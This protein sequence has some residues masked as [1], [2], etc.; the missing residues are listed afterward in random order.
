MD[1]LIYGVWKGRPYD[2]RRRLDGEQP[3]DLP[4][5]EFLSFNPGNPVTGFVGPQGFLIFDNRVTLAETLYRYYASVKQHSCGRCTPCRMG[6]R[7]IVEALEL[8][9][10]GR[11]SEV[12][13]DEIGR[14]ALQMKETSLCGIGETTPEAVLGAIEYFPELLRN[15]PATPPGSRSDHYSIATAPCIEACPANVNIPRYIDYV[16]DG[17][18]DLATGVLLEHY[19]LVGSCGRVCVR[20]CERACVRNKVDKAVAIKD[21]KR[22]ASD[23]AGAPIEELFCSENAPKQ[24]PVSKRVAVVGAGPAGITCAYHLLKLGHFV[25]IYE[26]ESAAGGMARLG[27]PAYRLPNRLLETE[28]EVISRM[29][30]KYLFNQALGRDFNIDDLFKKGYKAVFLGIGCALGQTLGLPGDDAGID[31]Y[32]KGLDFLLDV[33]R[34]EADRP[35]LDGDVVVVGCGNVAMD[36]CRTAR[37]LNTSGKVTVS[38][39]RTQQ[40]APADP[41]EIIAAKA[42][43]I[44]FEFLTAPKRIIVEDGRV[45]GIELVRMMETEPDASGRRGVKPIEGSE[46]IIPCRYVVAAIGQKMDSSIFSESDGI[47]LTRRGTIA[48][49]E[50]LS[51]SREGVF[52]G[53]DA[54]AGPTS[55]IAGMADGQTAAKSI[56]EYLMVEDTGFIPRRRLG[57]MIAAGRLISEVEPN[58]EV[59]FRP[60]HEVK[61]LDAC[62]RVNN[63]DEVEFP[64]TAHEA[65]EEAKRCMRCYRIYAVSTLMPIPGHRAVDVV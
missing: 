2:N 58:R 32:L 65:H 4:L 59:V 44:G 49:K 21:L 15:A 43:D 12:D 31:G 18:P 29:G 28:T 56:H 6:S 35:K 62:E 53:G 64:M 1:E 7:L 30:G 8:A 39:R 16:R 48:V 19:P 63:W 42:E 40:S 52:A 61:H 46:F 5:D 23:N 45:A 37:R 54:A 17:Q 34:N 57:K 22:F 27:I 14:I 3:E 60:R 10:D 38:Y 20:P 47:E 55:L 26:S 25:D 13:W 9:K 36:C 41:E 33:A 11:G 50:D 51:T 24:T